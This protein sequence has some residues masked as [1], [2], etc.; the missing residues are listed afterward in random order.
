MRTYKNK[1][2]R[3]TNGG[4]KRTLRSST[5]KALESKGNSRSKSADGSKKSNGSKGKSRTKEKN[6]NEEGSGS[7]P[8]TELG[9]NKNE[10]KSIVSKQRVIKMNTKQVEHELTSEGRQYISLMNVELDSEKDVKT[11]QREIKKNPVLKEQD[12]LFGAI[13]EWITVFMGDTHVWW[14]LFP[15]L[16]FNGVSQNDVLTGKIKRNKIPEPKFPRQKKIYDTDRAFFNGAHW[17][18]QQAGELERFD[19]YDKFQIFGTNQFC[20]TFSMMHLLDALPGDKNQICQ[21]WEGDP[22]DFKRFYYYTECALKFILNVAEHCKKTKINLGYDVGQAKYLND[23]I[24][25]IKYCLKYYRICIN[26]IEL[27]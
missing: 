3:Y 26:T 6:L 8:D 22:D 4:M 5:K 7:G 18:S 17:N 15:S 12:D 21:S 24:A 25:I 1:Q 13:F 20:Q 10:L 23:V 27:P 16:V 14:G 11:L 2:R 9:I 19:P